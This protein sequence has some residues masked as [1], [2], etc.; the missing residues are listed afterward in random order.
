MGFPD[1]AVVA[2]AMGCDLIGVAREAMLAVGCIQ[3][4]QCHTG[5]CPA[6]VATQSKWFQ[7][8]LNVEDKATR[9][10]RYLTSFRKEPLS[11]A[12]RRI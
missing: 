4:Q 6:G 3:A 9:M 5:N 8:G 12:Y 7:R 10:A 2:F 11:F 1:R